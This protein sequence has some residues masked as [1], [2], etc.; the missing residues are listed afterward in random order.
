[1]PRIGQ[2]SLLFRKNECPE[3][4]AHKP[5]IHAVLDTPRGALGNELLWACSDAFTKPLWAARVR[6]LEQAANRMPFPSRVA[7]SLGIGRFSDKLWRRNCA[8]VSD[9]RTRFVGVSLVPEE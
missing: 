1:L 8:A 6:A 7:L 9:W 5:S 4:S 3:K 2:S